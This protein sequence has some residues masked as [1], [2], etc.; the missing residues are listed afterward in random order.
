MPKTKSTYI[1]SQCGTSYAKMIGKC[2]SCGSFNTV[3]EEITSPARPGHKSIKA[4]STPQAIIDLSSEPLQ[5]IQ[6]PGS[7][8]NRVLGGGLVPGAVCLLGGEPGIGK[9]TL[10]LQTAL[11]MNRKVIYLSG[12]ES[13][14]QIK[15][16]AER[17]GIDNE[18][19]LVLNET[20]V[21]VAI[22]HLK[23]QQASFAIVDSIQTMY[24]KELES[25]P[26]SVSQIRESAALLIQYA[27][28]DNV[29]VI[30][31]GHITKDGQL[32]GPKLLEHMVDTVLQFEGDNQHSYRLLR[33]L[34]NRFGS[35]M[36][37]G[38]YEMR[39]DGMRE[40]QNPS[41]LLITQRKEQLSGVAVIATLEGNRPLLVESQALVSPAVYGT[42]QRNANGFDLKRL[43]MLLAIIEK[44]GNLP[45]VMNDVFVNI[46]GGMKISDPAA[47]LGIAMAIVSSF[48]AYSIPNKMMFSA[49]LGLSGELRSVSHIE[50][51][52]KEAEKLG[53]TDAFISS[54]TEVD[55]NSL[56]IRL[57]RHENIRQC[58][59]F[60]ED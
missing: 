9:S 46:A 4:A 51:R 56:S 19:C 21:E 11:R 40:V 6:L 57:H 30:L 45:M 59:E 34:K 36:E 7:E 2:F 26:G 43:N 58:L 27:K 16:R 53:Y 32:A 15:L 39:A 8:L 1:C 35:A 23:K 50:R 38:I 18:N 20:C 54:L 31:V 60:F 48:K 37:L 33:S 52:L 42:P 28:T 41:E 24:S 49:E 10:L 25:T 17:I 22:D 55:E 47:D 12:E 14:Q 29:P 44:R 3:Q 13:A 5:R